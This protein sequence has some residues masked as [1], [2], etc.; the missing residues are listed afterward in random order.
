MRLLK[1]L[2]YALLACSIICAAALA[3]PLEKTKAKAEESAVSGAGTGVTTEASAADFDILENPNSSGTHDQYIYDAAGAGKLYSFTPHY[4]ASNQNVYWRTE[5]DWVVFSFDS[6]GKSLYGDNV[7]WSNNAGYIYYGTSHDAADKDLKVSTNG[8]G[9]LSGGY[10]IETRGDVG[11]MAYV[12]NVK[13]SSYY[14]S[15]PEKVVFKKGFAIVL[16]DGTVFALAQDYAIYKVNGCY[17]PAKDLAGV[18]ALPGVETAQ[19]KVK[20]AEYANKELSVAFDKNL[21][22]KYGNQA[23]VSSG[24]TL[25]GAAVS[26]YSGYLRTDAGN[27]NKI[28]YSNVDLSLTN[29]DEFAVKSGFYTFFGSM[30]TGS[31]YV[32]EVIEDYVTWSSGGMLT[33]VKPR[34]VMI[35]QAEKDGNLVKTTVLTGSTRANW[36]YRPGSMGLSLILNDEQAFSSTSF[37]VYAGYITVN[38]QTVSEKTLLPNDTRAS[39]SNELHLFASSLSDLLVPTAEYPYPKLTIKSGFTVA[40]EQNDKCYATVIEQ[41]Y[42]LYYVDGFFLPS[43]DLNELCYKIDEYSITEL[44]ML[45][46]QSVRLKTDGNFSTDKAAIDGEQFYFAGGTAYFDYK[47][48]LFDGAAISKDTLVVSQV[49]PGNSLNINFGNLY[50]TMSD[51]SQY[52]TVT[53]K[54]GFTLVY[55]YKNAQKFY[56]VRLKESCTMYYYNGEFTKEKPKLIEGFSVSNQT[57]KSVLGDELALTV[58]YR[59]EDGSLSLTSVGGY[60]LSGF[61]KDTLGEQ[62]VTIEKGGV[63]DTFKIEVIENYIVRYKAIVNPAEYEI[64]ESIGDVY[65]LGF[66]YNGVPVRYNISDGVTVTGFDSSAAGL[67]TVTVA[68]EDFSEQIQIKINAEEQPVVPAPGPSGG[69]TPS[70]PNVTPLPASGCN[71]GTD[72]NNISAA[73]LFAAITY[74]LFTLLKKRKK[75]KITG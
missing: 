26:T 39:G 16:N 3:L 54:E 75:S 2:T 25:N 8:D 13:Q 42:D 37:G 67:I 71:A 49:E 70:N 1:K 35:E 23:V 21:N 56:G 33:G 60:T 31:M 64:G 66:Y 27:Q 40:C 43:S 4:I 32:V 52:R 12:T 73:A 69:E 19:V 47:N 9:A 58:Y 24:M 51:I 44:I 15:L 20:K 74:A 7:I 50:K 63:T 29:E 38:G 57:E 14:A 59:Y 10:E 22:I 62:T 18:K 48:V 17:M 41:D 5:R 46:D 53:F 11:Y 68:Y 72:V 45:G 30:S 61:D 28:V 55:G 34:A 65:V 36:A 6:K